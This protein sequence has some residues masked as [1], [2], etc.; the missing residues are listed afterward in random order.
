MS[1]IY[2]YD[3]SRLRV[4]VDL[5][6]KFCVTPRVFLQLTHEPRYALNKI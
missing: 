2:I 1:Y 5:N 3:I 6:E 4:K